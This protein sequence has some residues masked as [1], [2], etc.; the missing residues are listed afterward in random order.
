MAGA[1]VGA[2]IGAF[3]S[4]TRGAGNQ[5]ARIERRSDASDD[6]KRASDA[7]THLKQLDELR[8]QGAISI[9][10]YEEKKAELLKRI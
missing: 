6:G 1:V 10:E 8:Q 7:L 5:A 2:G 9:Q 4:I 3:L